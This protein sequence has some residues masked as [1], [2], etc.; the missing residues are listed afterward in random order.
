VL[1][2]PDQALLRIQ[3]MLQ[4][5][6]ELTHPYSLAFAHC[7]AAVAHQCRREVPQTQE[8]AEAAVSLASAQGFP[9][10]AAM[11][12][13]LRGWAC[14]LQGQGDTGMAH[15]RKG[16]TIWRTAGAE[17]VLPYFLVLSAEAYRA[18]GQV[19]K[20]LAVLTQASAVLNAT[21][22]RC[23]E[24]EIYRLRGEC[25]LLQSPAAVQ[26]AAASFRQALDVAQRQRA[27]LWELRAATSW[28]R[29]CDVPHRALAQQRLR[30]VYGWF[31]E[32]FALADLLQAREH[33]GASLGF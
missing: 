33:M 1:G 11:G 6:Q 18:T 20:C 5:A 15:I 2:Y 8:Q 7:A 4:L 12:A 30:E 32:A 3:T 23:W 16:L 9:L 27:R 13:I 14:A 28:S 29:H 21:G 10:W 24:A 31:T 25:L 26:Q 17:N 22:E 19:D